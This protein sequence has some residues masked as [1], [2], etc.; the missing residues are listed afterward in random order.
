MTSVFKFLI[1]V[2][3]FQHSAVSTENQNIKNTRDYFN[4]VSQDSPRYWFKFVQTLLVTYHNKSRTEGY[5]PYIG[6]NSKRM[7]I[8]TKTFWQKAR[9]VEYRWIDDRDVTTNPKTTKLW[10]CLP[11][12]AI[13]HNARVSFQGLMVICLAL[14]RSTRL[15]CK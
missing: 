13:R 3:Y 1:F 12:D 10:E 14:Q 11:Y 9:E 15:I 4:F 6:I 8:K 7:M 5:E 2:E